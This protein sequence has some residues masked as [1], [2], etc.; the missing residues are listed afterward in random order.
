MTLQLSKPASLNRSRPLP[1]F[2]DNCRATLELVIESNADAIVV[3]GEDHQILYTNPAAETLFGRKRKALVGQPFGMPVVLAETTELHILRPNGEQIVA[4]MRAVETDWMGS[5]AYVVSLRDVT[6]R[7][8]LEEELRQAHKM[9][10]LGNLAGGIAH[11]F[12]NLLTAILFSSGCL[13][14]QLPEEDNLH[15]YA[16]QIRSVA[17]RAAALTGQLLTFS[18][19]RHVKPT[20]HD[21][22]EIVTNMT[23][24]LSQI[25]GKNIKLT[26]STS[27]QPALVVLDRGQFEQ[28]IINLA[29]NARDAMPNGGALDYHVELIDSEDSESDQKYV[30]L[31]VTDTGCGMSSDVQARVFEPFFTTKDEGRGTG[32]GLATAHGVIHQAGG[33][34]MVNSVEGEGSVFRVILPYR[35]SLATS[36]EKPRV[37]SD[38][39]ILVVDDDHDVLAVMVDLLRMNGYKVE[40]ASDVNE[41]LQQMHRAEQ[42]YD[43]IVTDMVMPGGGGRQLADDVRQLTPNV[44]ILFVSGHAR[45]TLPD[46][47]RDDVRCEFVGKP[48]SATE[49]TVAINRLLTASV[50][51][52]QAISLSA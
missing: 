18:R 50:E 43:L 14:E 30:V 16:N 37:K 10:A 2:A 11:E 41:A 48:F 29:V 15:R 31:T 9:E 34:I 46:R 32:L 21:L 22:N 7:K 35:P 44:P 12:N 13:V 1:I 4:D 42:P 33:R 39:R 6:A 51:H 38:N 40:S 36:L 45:E 49:F 20:L 25:I 26:T 17:N 5:P 3:V 8:Q 24:L 28:V 52:N 27:H 19:K 23:T 47:Y